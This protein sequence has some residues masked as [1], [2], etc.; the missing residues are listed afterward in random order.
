[1]KIMKRL[2]LVLAV[3]ALTLATACSKKAEL[4]LGVAMANK[5]CPM[6]IEEGMVVTEIALEGDDIVYTCM[7]DDDEEI[8]VCD[9][10]DPYLK[11]IMKEAVLAGLVYESD[12]DVHDFIGLIKDT[13]STIVYRMVGTYSGCEVNIPIRYTEL[14]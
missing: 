12:S 9:M 10:D 1:M 5:E 7:I 3:V 2:A 13:E 6:E 8:T 14:K 11:A 4:K